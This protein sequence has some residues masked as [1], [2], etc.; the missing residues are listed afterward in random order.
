ML[1][2]NI[3]TPAPQVLPTNPTAE[4][5]KTTTITPEQYLTRLQTVTIPALIR[6]IAD[7]EATIDRMNQ[8]ELNIK[9]ILAASE[10]LDIVKE[11]GQ[12]HKFQIVNFMNGDQKVASFTL[13]IRHSKT[14]AAAADMP[15]WAQEL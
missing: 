1:K 15:E 8:T 10:Q 9:K 4:P 11:D 2:K 13:P 3:T 14:T 12:N 6:R 5:V 7:L